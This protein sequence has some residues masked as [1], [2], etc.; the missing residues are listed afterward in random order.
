MGKASLMPT[1][2]PLSAVGEDHSAG[3]I[4][5]MANTQS[6]TCT[7][8]TS[9]GSGPVLPSKSALPPALS[10]RSL[11]PRLSGAS[12]PSCFTAERRK[13]SKFPFATSLPS[14]ICARVSGVLP[15]WGPGGEQSGLVSA[16]PRLCLRG[17][18][19]SLLEL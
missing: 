18:G 3:E 6:L 13:E 9:P 11:R 17:R 1:S 19:P 15:P 8:P 5:N 10:S 2:G 7:A 16:L 14:H 4:C 12:L